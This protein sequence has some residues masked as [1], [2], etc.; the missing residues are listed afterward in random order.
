MH[1]ITTWPLSF[2]WAS[3]PS[4]PHHSLCSL[5]ESPGCPLFP[6]RATSFQLDASTFSSLVG[7][8]LSPY[9]PGTFLVILQ[10]LTLMLFLLLSPPSQHTSHCRA[11]TSFQGSSFWFQLLSRV[12]CFIHC[13]NQL[14]AWNFFT[15]CS[16]HGYFRQ[17]LPTSSL[18][19]QKR[20]QHTF[21]PPSFYTGE[22]DSTGLACFNVLSSLRPGWRGGYNSRLLV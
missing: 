10:D 3:F 8:A 5:F 11:G 21:P 2:L 16:K 6:G 4:L 13:W 1:L 12:S 17:Q 9:V 14:I 22:A 19:P 20:K 7:G 15:I 18:T